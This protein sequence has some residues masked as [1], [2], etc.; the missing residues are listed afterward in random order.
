MIAFE[1]LT[2]GY[3][4]CD[5]L[6]GL[7]GEAQAGTVIGLL[8][9]NGSGKSTLLKTLAGLL[10]ARG[11]AVQLGGQDIAD[12][13]LRSRARKLAYLAQIRHAIPYMQTRDVIALGRAPYRGPLGRISEAGESAIETA[14]ARTGSSA[15]MGRRYDSLSGG[16]QARILLARALAVGAPALLADEPI[17]ALDPRYQLSMMETLRAEAKSH[18]ALVITALH[19]LA[20]A[21]QYCDQLWV[22]D[23]GKIV[24]RGAPN[25]A[26]S[27][28]V[29]K[30]VFAIAPPRG[31]FQSAKLINKAGS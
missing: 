3:G 1:N 31:G 27:K 8:G 5:V 30:D 25:E 20:L 18:G 24:S 11:G 16:E 23:K 26:L 6:S 10:P 17:A 29:L 9:P 22:M 12:M 7:S 28:T 14:I 4:P 2:A 15:L 13:P 19:D 21:S